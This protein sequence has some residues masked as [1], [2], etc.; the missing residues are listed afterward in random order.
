MGFVTVIWAMKHLAVTLGLVAIMY[1]GTLLADPPLPH[2]KKFAQS[3][4]QK[5]DDRNDLRDLS[6]IVRSWETAVS[7][8]DRRGELAADRQLLTWLKYEAREERVEHNQ[9]VHKEQKSQ[10]KAS[11][12]TH[13]A[14]RSRI[15]QS[16]R[17]EARVEKQ[18]RSQQQSETK[19]TIRLA[20]TLEAMQ[21]KF[22]KRR[23]S[24]AD[25]RKKR[26]ILAELLLLEKRE[27]RGSRKNVQKVRKRARTGS[28]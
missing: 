12:V 14:P 9:A 15:A 17:A 13:V 21:P 24:P 25:Y 16:K 27:L 6:S 20:R 2:S 8:K 19:K 22:S 28:R 10:K 26:Q 23:A 7:R 3:K 1:E 4:S 11:L 5:Q 18:V